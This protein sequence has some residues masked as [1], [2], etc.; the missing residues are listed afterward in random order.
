M[1]CSADQDPRSVRRGPADP[2]RR[3]ARERRTPAV[4]LA[5]RQRARVAIPR[6][7]EPDG[8]RGLERPVV[9]RRRAPDPPVCDPSDE[10]PNAL[11]PRPSNPLADIDVP[12][13]RG[14]EQ[15]RFAGRPCR[16]ADGTRV[17]RRL[18]TTT[19]DPSRQSGRHRLSAAR[20]ARPAATAS[21]CRPRGT[22]HRH[23]F[24]GTESQRDIVQN[25][26]VVDAVGRVLELEVHR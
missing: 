4:P 9:D 25:V 8:S 7:P 24:A 6:L 2:A 21:S 5:A 18:A 19:R 10:S 26:R 15:A 22:D 1:P 14:L 11:R 17:G 16:S 3:R 13:D 23:D 12:R 20:T